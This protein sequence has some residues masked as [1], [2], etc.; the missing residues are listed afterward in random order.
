M[1][2]AFLLV[3]KEGKDKPLKTLIVGSALSIIG[4]QFKL[5]A[6]DNYVEDKI[7]EEL[8]QELNHLNSLTEEKN[9]LMRQM[10]C[11]RCKN[12]HGKEYG[13]IKLICGIHPYGVDE[14][15][16]PDYENRD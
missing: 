3:I 6:W 10:R 16:C 4:V 2:T 7:R 15:I 8:E 12:F 11:S 1:T 5:K 14:D 13:G 9:S